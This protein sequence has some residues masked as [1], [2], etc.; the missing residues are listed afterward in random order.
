MDRRGF[1]KILSATSAGIATS[2]CGHKTDALIPMLVAEQEIVPGEEQWH[3]AVCTECAAGCGTIVRVMEGVRTV[4]RKGEKFRERVAAIKKIEGNPLDPVSGGRLCA[5]GQAAVQALY[6]PDRLR[7]PMKRSGDRGKFVPVSWDEAIAEA[8]EK[9]AHADRGRVAFVTGPHTGTRSLSIARFMEA[10]GAPAPAMCSLLDFSAERKAA[11]QV[12]GWKGLPVYDLAHAHTILGVGVDFLGGWASPVYYTRQ[13]GAFRQ[14]R[15]TVRGRFLHA[16]SRLSLTAAAADRWL[17]IRPGTEEQFLTAVGKILFDSAFPGVDVSA[18]IAACGTDERRVREAAAELKE[19]E[20][21]LI[22][23]GL[24]LGHHLNWMLGNAG[25]AGGVLPPGTERPVSANAADALAGAQV[26]LID[27][28]NPAYTLPGSLAHAETIISFAGLLDDSAMQADLI[29]PG[30]HALESEIAIVP[31]VSAQPAV[32][33]GTPFVRPLYETRAVEKTLGDLAK[34]MGVEYR[35]ATVKDLLPADADV[36]AATRQGGW[37]GPAAER[38]AERA[39][40]MDTP[41]QP[42]STAHNEIQFQAY[43]SVQFG[44]GSGANVPWLQEMPDPASSAIWGLPVEIDP[45]TAAHYGI[46]TGDT[47]RVESS[48]ASLEAPAYVHPGAIPG[49][50]SMAIGGGRGPN[51]LTLLAGAAVT[52]VR[53][54]RVGRSRNFIQFAAPDREEIT[55]R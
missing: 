3:P 16:E 10:V 23:S 38:R 33:I 34:K 4:E 26:V 49:V 50:V 46:A 22:V 35:A 2:G 27:W 24:A 41:P 32:S 43:P 1:F 8:A 47:V 28:A 48:H 51:P 42:G 31:A 21:P 5:R 25:K 19:S 7:G 29:L 13:Y 9:L 20:A 45:Q 39:G 54:A 14:G 18:L 17:P 40:H 44:D 36:T 6:H 55:H 30:H 15:K 52:T 37:W 12:F 53:L 11:E